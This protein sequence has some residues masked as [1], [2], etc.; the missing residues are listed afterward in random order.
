[1]GFMP[2]RFVDLETAA[3]SSGLRMVLLTTAPSPWSD[4]IRALCAAKELEAVAVK[5]VPGSAEIARWSR[6]QNSPAVLYRD[7]LPRSGWA[8]ILALLE[9]LSPG[10]IPPDRV[11]FFGLAHEMLGERGLAWARRGMLIARGLETEGREGLSPRASQFL[12][13]RYGYSTD[14]APWCRQ[15]VTD[16]LYRLQERLGDRSFFYDQLSALDIYC[17]ACINTFRPLP[18]SI[19][20]LPEP[21]RKAFGW[22]DLE[23]PANLLALRDRHAKLFQLDAF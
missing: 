23:L 11:E 3:Q 18:D 20:P 17:I 12:V 22:C 5:A 7:E 19:R 4:A 10:H 2:I 8:E 16:V 1:M 6:V 13:P 14:E 21:A 15:R 9:R